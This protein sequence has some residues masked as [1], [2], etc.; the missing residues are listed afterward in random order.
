MIMMANMQEDVNRISQS[1]K[2]PHDKNSGETLAPKRLLGALQEFANSGC[3]RER[4]AFF[5]KRWPGFLSFLDDF[6]AG[7]YI[8]KLP[9]GLPE[10]EHARMKSAG[11]WERA[12]FFKDF[13]DHVRAAWTG[14]ERVIQ[15]LLGF[16]IEEL[17]ADSF[18]TK[19][20]GRANQIRPDW[21]RSGFRY[22]P[23]NTFQ[24]AVYELLKHSR[25]AR[26]CANPDCTNPYF[27]ATDH[28]QKFCSPEC[29]QPAQKEW[30]RRW[31]EQHGQ[32]WRE[33]HGK[34]HTKSTKRRP[35]Q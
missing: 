18:E 34:K 5:V 4:V 11:N 14:N 22:E 28:R 31:W 26:V 27:I 16:G 10:A 24:A 2:H 35:R 7:G 12:D 19:V 33:Q 23:Q 25:Q 17:G 6:A 30:R 8:T 1:S 20:G 29:T 9:P 3:E 13:R 15:Y 21:R 32:Q